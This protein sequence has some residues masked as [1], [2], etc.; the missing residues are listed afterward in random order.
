MKTIQLRLVVLMALL[1]SVSLAAEAQ[2]ERKNV[3]FSVELHCNNC[4]MKVER[5]LAY[6]R[7]VQ[8]LKVNLN[9]KTVIVTY[10]TSRTDVLKLLE[11]IKKLGFEAK[12][13]K[14]EEKTS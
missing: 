9:E 2:R 4:K 3:T 12:E 13:V 10:D 6:E 11:A 1:F 5:N 14:P 7:G 8:D